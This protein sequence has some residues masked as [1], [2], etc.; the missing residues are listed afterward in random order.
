MFKYNKQTES[1]SN[2][3]NVIAVNGVKMQFKQT[4]LVEGRIL[5]VLAH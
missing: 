4:Q 2:S 5:F 1:G 3:A